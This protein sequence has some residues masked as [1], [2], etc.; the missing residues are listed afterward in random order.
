MLHLLFIECNDFLRLLRYTK[1]KI[2]SFL[3]HTLEKHNSYQASVIT[4]KFNVFVYFPNQI[5]SIC[6]PTP[7]L[8]F[9]A[10][11]LKTFANAKFAL[12]HHEICFFYFYH[13]KKCYLE[14]FFHLEKA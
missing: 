9:S 12:Y 10:S 1:I 11:P 13:I 6:L 2:V 8:D 14:K 7:R 3:N 4:N 5:S